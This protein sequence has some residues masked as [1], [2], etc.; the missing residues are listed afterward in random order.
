M[1]KKAIVIGATSGIGKAIAEALVA[2]GWMVGA[3]GRRTE[4]LEAMQEATGADRF[5]Y[6]YM[7]VIADD[8]I[9][10][11]DSLIAEM[12]HP[13]LLFY[14]SGIGFQNPKLV[15]ET[16]LDIVKTNCIGMVRIVDHFV[17]Y[18]RNH[19]DYYTKQNRAHV[20]VIT[21]VAGTDGLGAAPS[22]SASKKMQST[23]ITALS[24]LA[25]MEKIQVRF[26]DVKPGF[27]RTEILDPNR[28]YPMILPVEKA[29]RLIMRAVKKR[30][31][32][33][34]FDWRFRLLVVY[35][36]M[37]PR[38]IWERSTFYKK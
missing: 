11:L 17:N 29:C 6:R 19:G 7:D 38:W 9:D 18:V 10:A 25:R 23:Y 31:R 14:A 26:T 33:F 35:W 37:I 27:V 32:E 34:V 28:K 8:A 21:S 13:D 1:Q 3:T 5:L 36:K 4:R 22:Y 16:E 2:E 30:K 24:Q 20:A 12:G 15:E